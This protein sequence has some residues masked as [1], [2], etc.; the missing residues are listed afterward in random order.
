MHFHS[1]KYSIKDLRK[2]FKNTVKTNLLLRQKTRTTL[3][4]LSNQHVA[5][6]HI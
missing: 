6:K 3:P 4:Q 1:D 2:K 5:Y